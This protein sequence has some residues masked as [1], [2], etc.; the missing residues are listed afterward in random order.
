MTLVLAALM[1][2]AQNPVVVL[3]T[4]LG[5]IEIEVDVQH[6]PVT[7]ANFL[8]YVDA[9]LYNGGFFHRTVTRLPDNQPKNDVKIDVIQGAMDPDRGSQEMPPITLERT[10]VTGLRHLDGTVSMARDGANSATNEFFICIGAQPALDFGGKRNPDGQGFAAFGHV[11]KGME[12]V[13]K[14]HAS[15]AEGQSLVPPVQIRRASLR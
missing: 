3:N 10:S 2:A 14:I 9:G 11:V 1:L 6:A 7:A 15:H 12:V 5:A 8:K 4:D 13:R